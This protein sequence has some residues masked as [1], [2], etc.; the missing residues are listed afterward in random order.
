MK[1]DIDLRLSKICFWLRK[2]RITFL[3]GVSSD[4]KWIQIGH[5]MKASRKISVGLFCW[6]RGETTQLAVE[7]VLEVL[8]TE[9]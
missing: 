4:V 5:Y 3:D 6:R 2:L 7:G 9:K 1:K 8:V